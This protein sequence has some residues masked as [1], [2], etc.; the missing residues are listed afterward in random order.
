MHNGH[1]PYQLSLHSTLFAQCKPYLMRK[2]QGSC[3]QPDACAVCLCFGPK[4]PGRLW[5]LQP[6]HA[7]TQP[8]KTHPNLRALWLM[9]SQSDYLRRFAFRIE[10]SGVQTNM[11]ESL[12]SPQAL[13]TCESAACTSSEHMIQ[14]RVLCGHSCGLSVFMFHGNSRRPL[15]GLTSRRVCRLSNFHLRVCIEI[16]WCFH[17]HEKCLL[18]GGVFFDPPSDSP[19]GSTGSSLAQSMDD[20]ALHFR[21]S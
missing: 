17:L 6:K 12:V 11:R 3:R 10:L 20:I 13:S 7:R 15:D 2:S 1:E 19:A 8:S 21:T 18:A 4:E 5:I 14:S 9:R 16:V